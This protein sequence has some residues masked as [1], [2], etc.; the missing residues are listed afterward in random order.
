MLNFSL[1]AL[2]G[3]SATTAF[4]L[5][6]NIPQN[7]PEGSHINQQVLLLSSIFIALAALADLLILPADGELF[8]LRQMLDNLAFFAAV[9]LVATAILA[10]GLQKTWSKPAWGRWL[11]GLFAFFELLRR[12]QYGEE[13]SQFIAAASAALL[14]FGAIRITA[15]TRLIALAGAA[16]SAAGL[17]CFSQGSLLP[18][19]ANTAVYNFC[20]SAGLPL[21]AVASLGCVRTDN[22]KQG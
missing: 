11:I 18:H 10:L 17:I 2:A 7:Q 15:A 8:T 19:L 5:K 13:Y 3:S 6:R 1:I 20:L 14:V 21:L 22:K 12:M 9:P 16:I 4:W